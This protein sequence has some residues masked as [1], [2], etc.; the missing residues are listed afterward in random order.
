[1]LDAKSSSPA[2][3]RSHLATAHGPFALHL[4]GRELGERSTPSCTARRQFVWRM[5]MGKWAVFPYEKKRGILYTY[6]STRIGKMINNE[7]LETCWCLCLMLC[8]TLS[9]PL[10]WWDIHLRPSEIELLV[11]IKKNTLQFL[12]FHPIVACNLESHKA[13]KPWGLCFAVMVSNTRHVRDFLA[14]PYFLQDFPLPEVFQETHL[15][16]PETRET[17]RMSASP[18]RIL[19]KKGSDA[20]RWLASCVKLFFFTW[21][22]PPESQGWTRS[23]VFE[24]FTHVV[25]RLSHIC[26]VFSQVP[27]ARSFPGKMWI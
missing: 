15:R 11:I 9:F 6:T 21:E 25:P 12:L 17:Q 19:K 5:R 13:I 27:P 26:L 22:T 23:K 20:S 10:S 1:M 16:A 24:G 2:V 8:V 18:M 4:C 14:T 3:H 7:I